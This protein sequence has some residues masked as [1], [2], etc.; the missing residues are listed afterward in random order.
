MML[1]STAKECAH[2]G[3]FYTEDLNIV[4]ENLAS[5]MI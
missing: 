2:L 5:N 1:P 4:P 3:A